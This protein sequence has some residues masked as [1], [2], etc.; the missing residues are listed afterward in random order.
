ERTF[1]QLKNGHLNMDTLVTLGSGAALLKA[2]VLF[3]RGS[4][5]PGFEAASTIVVFILFGR[6]LET[7]SRRKT[8]SATAQLFSTFQHHVTRINDREE[9][10]LGLDLRVGDR[11]LL[12][13]GEVSPVDGV[14]VEGKTQVSDQALSGEVAPKIV[15]PGSKILSGTTVVESP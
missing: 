9:T 8:Y 13:P 7:S 3:F 4:S 12:K 5:M 6:Y 15:G 1:K 10:V 11:I 2:F 14:I